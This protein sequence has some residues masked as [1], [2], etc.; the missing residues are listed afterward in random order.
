LEITY[1]TAGAWLDCGQIYGKHFAEKFIFAFVFRLIFRVV[2][3]VY[4]YI[5]GIAGD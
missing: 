4:F 3:W 1:R 5:A 2:V